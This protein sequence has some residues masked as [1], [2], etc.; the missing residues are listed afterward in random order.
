MKK[1]LHGL[2][3]W[4]AD[5][6]QG[7]AA[8]FSGLL[9]SNSEAGPAF[10]DLLPRYGAGGPFYEVWFGKVDLAPG[11]ALWFRYTLL[12]GLT[13][14]AS[15]WAI[16][17]KDGEIVTGKEVHSIG[18]LKLWQGQERRGESLLDKGIFEVESG[19]L[20]PTR[21]RG[22]AGAL[23]WDLR[24]SDRQRAFSHLPPSM[25]RLHL[26]RSE[27]L[28]AM[29]D[30]EFHGHLSVGEEL[31]EVRGAKGMVGHIFG[32]KQAHSWAW[33]HCSSFDSGEDFVLDALSA[34]LLVGGRMTRPLTSAVVFQGERRYAFSGPLS[35]VL[36][37][38]DWNSTR[39]K[40]SG[41]DGAAELF[42]LATLKR[43]TAIVE[44]T[45][46]DG[47]RLWCHNS[48][49]SDLSICF[50][51]PEKDERRELRATG[52]AAFEVVTRTRPMTTPDL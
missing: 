13:R 39:W 16:L 51:D 27:Y 38:S 28:G 25:K 42:G 29:L 34:R 17:F 6:T 36:N 45:D 10:S 3:H 23:S 35:L 26:S 44:Y 21:A 40:F 5:K 12:D 49:L 1:I 47:S 7:L 48:K 33:C 52:T 8:A 14:D 41:S 24:F 9:G 22:K 19:R 18:D 20:T 2:E 30:V 15:V 11:R 46:T 32:S 37:Q 50:Y 4:C 31:L 43:P